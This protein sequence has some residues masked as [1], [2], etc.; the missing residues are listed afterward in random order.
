MLRIRFAH[1]VAGALLAL[2][3]VTMPAGAQDPIHFGTAQL[4]EVRTTCFTICFGAGCS[5]SGT[6]S[7]LLVDMPF[8]VR[9]IR[10]GPNTTTGELCDNNPGDTTP[11][12]LPK[13]IGPGERIVF[14]VDLVPTQLGNFQSFLSVNG[15]DLWDLD[16]SVAPVISCTPGTAVTC[17]AD[18]R[19]QT[20]VFWRTQFGTR[21]PAPLVPVTSDDSGL[22]YF[23]DQNNWELLLKVLNGCPVN[24]HFWVFAGATTN[25]E[26]TVTVVDTQTQDVKTYFNPLGNPAPPVQDTSA[27]ATCP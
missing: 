18:D 27:F 19:F 8:F 12:S 25:V 11:A 23:F 20:R 21:G 1:V 22:F 6:I 26:V 13:A 10:V 9:G 4:G 24:N 2:A 7:D 14:D 15:G 3:T 17:L 5:G 16:A